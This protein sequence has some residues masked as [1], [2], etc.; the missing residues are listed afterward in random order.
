MFWTPRQR[1]ALSLLVLLILVYALIRFQIYPNRI[2]TPQP[3][4]GPRAAELQDRL[5]PNTASAADLAALPNV[6]P[7]MARRI[8]EEREEFQKSHPGEV[9]YKKLEDLQRVKGIGAATLENLR[10]HLKF[11]APTQPSR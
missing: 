9:A 10:P 1:F 4:E 11:P 8:V 7:A 3:A 5:E 6:G 2:S